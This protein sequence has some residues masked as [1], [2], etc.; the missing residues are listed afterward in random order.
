MLR[1]RDGQ[2]DA[3]YFAQLRA[4]AERGAVADLSTR[5]SRR[6]PERAAEGDPDLKDIRDNRPDI[7]GYET[8]VIAT[9]KAEANM[10]TDAELVTSADRLTDMVQTDTA[11]NF[12]V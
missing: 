2:G 3:V 7:A 5:D 1:G 6:F 8:Q 11:K 12:L 9:D 4:E 10:K